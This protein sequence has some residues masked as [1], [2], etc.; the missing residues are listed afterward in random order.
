MIHSHVLR[1]PI[2]FN[3]RWLLYRQMIE[4]KADY[5]RAYSTRNELPREYFRKQRRIVENQ[6]ILGWQQSDCGFCQYH[7]MEKSATT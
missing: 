3:T 5:A 1:H 2:V 6:E 7:L 4:L